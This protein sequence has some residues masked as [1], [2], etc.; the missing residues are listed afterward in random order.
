MAKDLRQRVGKH[1]KGTQRTRKAVHGNCSVE[2]A[3]WTF[4]INAPSVVSR[5]R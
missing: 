1:Y 3:K 4:P 5:M 2:L